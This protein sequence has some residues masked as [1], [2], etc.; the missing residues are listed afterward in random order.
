[1]IHMARNTI[2]QLTALASLTIAV[3]ACP[4]PVAGDVIVLSDGRRLE[5]IVTTSTLVPDVILF[6]D[7]VN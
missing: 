6:S 7:H 4:R 3:W 1:M 2:G 5:G